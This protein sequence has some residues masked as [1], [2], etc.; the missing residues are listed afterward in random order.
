MTTA[1]TIVSPATLAGLRDRVLADAGEADCTALEALG[2]L[3]DSELAAYYYGYAK[4]A[5][6][7]SREGDL[8]RRA[9][10]CA[11]DAA[12]ALDVIT[13]AVCAQVRVELAAALR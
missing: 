1:P 2:E 12:G 13:P 5:R 3:T 10:L 4:A 9:A 6:N 7:A 8:H 11:L